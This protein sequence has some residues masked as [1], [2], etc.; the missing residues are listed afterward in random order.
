MYCHF[1]NKWLNLHGGPMWKVV[2]T[3]Q[4]GSLSNS[5][6]LLTSEVNIVE[7]NIYYCVLGTCKHSCSICSFNSA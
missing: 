5:S 2:T 4:G 7:L 6:Q 1:G 3:E